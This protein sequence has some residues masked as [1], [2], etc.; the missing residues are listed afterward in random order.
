[1]LNKKSLA[2]D[3][4]SVL[5]SWSEMRNAF[6]N[7]GIEDGIDGIPGFY[8]IHEKLEDIIFG[9]LKIP[10]DNMATKPVSDVYDALIRGE[11]SIDEHDKKLDEIGAFCRDHYAELLIQVSDGTSSFDDLWD[12]TGEFRDQ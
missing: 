12:S 7:L 5:R 1:M 11:I 3:L 2:R 10:E 9:L 4:C 8:D 6:V